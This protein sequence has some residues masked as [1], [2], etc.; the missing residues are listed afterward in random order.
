MLL[1][2]LG[3]LNVESVGDGPDVVE[4]DVAFASLDTADVVAVESGAFGEVLLRP[5][6]RATQLADAATEGVAVA[7]GMGHGRPTVRTHA[8]LI[9]TL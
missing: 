9:Y 3:W 1:E 5:A 6:A 4:G 7:G 2:Q 8:P